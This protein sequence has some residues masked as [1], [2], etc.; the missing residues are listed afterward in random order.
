MAK[1]STSALEAKQLGLLRPDD[2]IVFNSFELLYVAKKVPRRW[3]KPAGARRCP[4]A[5]SSSPATSAPRR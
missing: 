5:I 3:P 4:L 1:V 2:V